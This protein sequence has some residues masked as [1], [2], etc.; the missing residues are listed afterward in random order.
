MLP[1]KNVIEDLSTEWNEWCIF[2]DVTPLF[3]TRQ[4]E[5][6]E[7]TSKTLKGNRSSLP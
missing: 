5:Q 2:H 6:L 1:L 4:L 7:I 3:L